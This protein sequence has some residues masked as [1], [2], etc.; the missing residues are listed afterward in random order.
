MIRRISALL[1]LTA[2]ASA[3]A[4]AQVRPDDIQ[5]DL[6]KKTRSLLQ[7]YAGGAARGDYQAMRNFAYVWS[8][9]AA[10]EKTEAA[11]VGC[12]WYVMILKKHASKAH[13]GDRSN[14]DLYCGRL[15]SDQARQAGALVSDLQSQLD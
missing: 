4:S 14:K 2:A 7:T 8:T 12:A 13:D 3:V 15:S 9:D 10:R 5:R 1:M 11:A 6:S